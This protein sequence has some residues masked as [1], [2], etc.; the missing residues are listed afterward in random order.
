MRLDSVDDFTRLL[1][2]CAGNGACR[3]HFVEY[4]SKPLWPV[5][6]QFRLDMGTYLQQRFVGGF[7]PVDVTEPFDAH[8]VCDDTKIVA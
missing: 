5:R 1:F 7:Q 4:L 6:F 3:Q 8:V 2:G